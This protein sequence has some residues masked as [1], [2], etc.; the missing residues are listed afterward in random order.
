MKLEF[1]QELA[2]ARMYRG[3]DT[4]NGK[5]AEELGRV[6][7][8]MIMMVEILRWEDR[9]FAKSYS[10]KTMWYENFTAFRLQSTDLHNLLTVLNNQEDYSDKIKVNRNIAVP[11]LQIRRYLRDIESDIRQKGVDRSFF[12]KLEE[13]FKISDSACREVRRAVADWD[14]NSETEKHTVRYQIKNLLY[15]KNQQN[16]LLLHFISK[17][18]V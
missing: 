5:T 12:K 13:Y 16:D 10:R 18:R 15:M 2:E 9:D 1:I 6:A 3:R 8:L 17:L 7:F 14:D 4:L 11:V